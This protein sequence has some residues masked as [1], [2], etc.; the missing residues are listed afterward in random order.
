MK[1]HTFDN[2]QKWSEKHHKGWMD[3]LRIVFGLLLHL[4]GLYFMYHSWS[5]MDIGPYHVPKESVI[6][7]VHFLAFINILLGTFILIGVGTRIS[8]LILIP[9]MIIELFFS[10]PE[11]NNTFQILYSLLILVLSVFFF[12]QGDGRFSMRQY[13]NNSAISS[14]VKGKVADW[15]KKESAS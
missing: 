4:K 15:E 13:M 1:L 9:T 2:I 14:R 6:L 8:C 11:I 7:L 3:I 5:V 12:L 10:N